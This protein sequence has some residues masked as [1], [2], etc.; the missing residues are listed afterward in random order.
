MKLR[1]V[2]ARQGAVWVRQGLRIFFRR[3]LAFGILLFI[4]MSVGPLLMFTVAPLATVG[5]MIA[6]RL[7]L[8]GA[9]PLPG[10]FVKPL[11]DR[12]QRRAQIQLGI[13][14]AIGVALV[15]WM[16]D[17]VGGDALDALRDSLSA[18]K[19]SAADIEP[20]LS[21][22]A[23]TMGWLVLMGGIAALAVPFWH[24][25]A[26]V[27]WGGLSAAKALFFSTVAC[28]RNKGALAV[29]VLGWGAVMVLLAL[30]GNLLFAALGMQQM[31]F[32]VLMPVML[33]LSAAF[34]AS[35]YFSFAES[36]ESPALSAPM[37]TEEASR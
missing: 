18:G 13:V 22:P 36:F 1:I 7:A 6:T 8:E 34:Y 35:L 16:G 20:L 21:D 31:A 5:F 10:V 28:W 4:Y 29:F 25:P 37:R 3:P 26:L 24:A 19:G 17:M 15:F 23:L 9:F 33:M 30:A 14:Y 2:P 27:Y 11:A 32:A 12:A